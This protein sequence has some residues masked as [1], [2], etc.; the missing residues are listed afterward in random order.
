MR[1]PSSSRLLRASSLLLG[2]LFV[3]LGSASIAAAADAQKQA[4][5]QI[6]AAA[7][8]TLKGFKDIAKAR[9]IAAEV[10]LDA[11][12]KKIDLGL[13]STQTLHDL[14]DVLDAFQVDMAAD[15]SST[16]SSFAV[17]K[18]IILQELSN[19]GFPDVGDQP[20]DFLIGHRGTCETFHS[21]M[22]NAID[23]VYSALAKRVQKT[24]DAFDAELGIGV[25]FRMRSPQEFQESAYGNGFVP[26]P[27][28]VDLLLAFSDRSLNDD[29]TIYVSGRANS[30]D[31]PMTISLATASG[32]INVLT[33]VTANGTGRYLFIHSDEK[34]G[35]RAYTIRHPNTLGGFAIASITVP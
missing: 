17:E 23:D 12:D 35:D 2:V 4:A 11:I 3:T 7:K 28:T 22:V 20:F 1:Q 21:N 31:G 25:T 29:G 14:F 18:A 9:R 8:S 27:L 19:A 30:N 15:V 6:K 32:V 26:S 10:Q 5:K 13:A 24:A 34:E 33:Q 16:E